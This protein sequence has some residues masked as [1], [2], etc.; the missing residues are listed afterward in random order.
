M[1]NKDREDNA[2]P[3]VMLLVIILGLASLELD[4]VVTSSS[5]ILKITLMVVI[6][7]TGEKISVKSIPRF[8]WNPFTTSLALYRL[9]PSSSLLTDRPTCFEKPSFLLEA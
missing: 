6:L 7:T 1:Q 2:F 4:E 5:T 9:L 8:C 3:F